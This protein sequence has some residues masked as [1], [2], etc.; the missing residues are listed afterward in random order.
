VAT[1]PSQIIVRGKGINPSLL[2][3]YE[4]EGIAAYFTAI[5]GGNPE[6]FQVLERTITIRDSVTG[7]ATTKEIAY[8]FVDNLETRNVAFTVFIVNGFELGITHRIAPNTEFFNVS[9]DVIWNVA[10]VTDRSANEILPAASQQY[11]R[12]IRFAIGNM[13]YAIDGTPHTNDVAPFI[14]PAYNRTMIPLRAVSEALGAE[15]EWIAATR[16][17]SIATATVEHQLTVDVPLPDGMGVPVLL[18][19]RVLVPIRYVAEILGATTR[20]DG[21]NSAVYIYM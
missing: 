4:R 14:D 12:T 20:W 10:S 11:A 17:V 8:V 3:L 13:V 21:V 7:E 18:D 15:V 5:R 16:T 2:A 1:R 19:N 9:N 6:S